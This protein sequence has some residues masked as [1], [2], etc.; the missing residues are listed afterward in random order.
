MLMDHAWLPHPEAAGQELKQQDPPQGASGVA[1]VKKCLHWVTFHY[2]WGHCSWIYA[3]QKPRVLLENHRAI[4][5]LFK[6]LLSYFSQL[7]SLFDT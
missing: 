5:Y 2:N 3:L 7:K 1:S 4:Q 6:K